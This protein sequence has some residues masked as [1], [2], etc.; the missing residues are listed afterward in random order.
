MRCWCYLSGARCKWFAYGPA[1]VTATPSSLAS[2]KSRFVQHFWCRLTQVV[3]EKMPLN[4]CLSVWQA[5]SRLRYLTLPDLGQV[6][7]PDATKVTGTSLRFCRPKRFIGLMVIPYKVSQA[8]V[9]KPPRCGRYHLCGNYIS[10]GVKGCFF[11]LPTPPFPQ[12][13]IIGAVVIV[14]RVRGKIIRSVLC[15]CT[16]Q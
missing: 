14:W 15:N 13:D 10:W 2:L 6:G 7:I 4:R 5:K 11:L 9:H 3:L 8:L 16:V 1:D 12:I